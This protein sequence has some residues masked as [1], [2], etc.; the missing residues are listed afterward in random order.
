MS[1][2]GENMVDVGVHKALLV[3]VLS[4][5]QDLGGHGRKRWDGDVH[6]VPGGHGEEGGDLD[7]QA[8]ETQVLRP[9][10]PSRGHTEISLRTKKRFTKVTWQDVCSDVMCS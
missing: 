7:I 1:D 5:P 10:A 4:H 2:L 3:S 9:W 8:V 6:V